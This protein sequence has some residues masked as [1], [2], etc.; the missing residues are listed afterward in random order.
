[1][2]PLALKLAV[3]A[4]AVAALGA[5]RAP[6]E[7]DLTAELRAA[8]LLSPPLD[9]ATNEKL[10]QTT[11]AVALGGMRTLVAALWHLRAYGFF[12]NQEWARLEDT[13]HTIV[14]LAPH[15][16][17]YWDTA[18][19]HLAYNAAANYLED[20]QLPPVRRR[21][22]WRDAIRRGQGFL[23][24]GI[25]NNPDDWLLAH[26]LGRLLDDKNK[27]PDPAQA[28]H[29][30]AY[31][32]ARGA[33]AYVA[34][35][36]LYAL[37]RVPGKE[38]DALALARRLFADPRN[39]LP[40][41]NCLCFALEAQAG[42]NPATLVGQVFENPRQAWDQLATYHGRAD[43]GYPQAGVEAALRT[44][45]HQLQIPPEKSVFRRDSR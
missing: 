22:L 41:L 12:E 17:F 25:R 20:P 35:N 8:R 45:E 18:S 39:R 16:R 28:A 7:R 9:L 29:W 40:S 38:A 27:L 30:F 24:R 23:E 21:Q 3:T 11:A 13:F 43:E 2:R 32:A 31:S 26:R 14:T 4:A 5:V 42:A 44:L 36:Q 6:L 15:T 37:A 1:M 10:G 33:P 19:W 34:R